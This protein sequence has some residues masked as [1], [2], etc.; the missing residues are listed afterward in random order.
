M[1]MRMVDDDANESNIRIRSPSEYHEIS[2]NSGN[3]F[4][5]RRASFCRTPLDGGTG[6]SPA[7]CMERRA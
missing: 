6:S 2:E 5:C 3:L 7:T 4:D 1:N